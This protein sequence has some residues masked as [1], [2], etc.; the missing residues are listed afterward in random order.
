MK[1]QMS[2][3]GQF[4]AH[5]DASILEQCKRAQNTEREIPVHC[6]TRGYLTRALPCVPW[7]IIYVIYWSVAKPWVNCSRGGTDWKILM[8]IAIVTR[9]SD[10]AVGS[11][12]CHSPIN[13]LQPVRDGRNVDHQ[14][15]RDSFL[16]CCKKRTHAEP[17][18]SGELSDSQACLRQHCYR[19]FSTPRSGGEWHSGHAYC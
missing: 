16:C 13:A 1:L 12:D 7:F 8:Y 3:G 17:P 5:G 15:V 4:F 14:T 18:F 2:K 11:I 10:Y 9:R 6:T 19:C